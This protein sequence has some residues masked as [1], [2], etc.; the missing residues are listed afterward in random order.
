MNAR[1]V[2]SAAAVLVFLFAVAGCGTASS[3]P[4]AATGNAA[5]APSHPA[6]TAAS[7]AGQ[8]SAGGKGATLKLTGFL[9]YDGPFTG[10]FV[11]YHDNEPYFELEGQHPYHLDIVVH[12]MREGTFTVNPQSRKNGFSK[13]DP[14]QPVMDVRGLSRVDPPMPGVILWQAGGTITFADGGDTGS[15]VADWVNGE[16][17]SQK[18]HA[19]VHWQNCKHN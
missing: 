6:S 15:L 4:G 10:Y 17:E 5:S 3:S 8:R 13:T 9:T 16:N 7:S 14:G 18:V 19:E 1:R 11:C 12:K 2:R